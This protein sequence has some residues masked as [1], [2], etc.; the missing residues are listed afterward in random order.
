MRVS[1]CSTTFVHANQCMSPW[2]YTDSCRFSMSVHVH[3]CS[4][5]GYSAVPIRA[6]ALRPH[7]HDLKTYHKYSIDIYW[8]RTV[9]V[10]SLVPQSV[11]NGFYSS[12]DYRTDWLAVSHTLGLWYPFVLTRYPSK[13]NFIYHVGMFRI[14]CWNTSTICTLINAWK[15]I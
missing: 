7:L 6:T 15:N 1:R 11:L 12:C 13:S 10:P 2:S 14:S 3:F 4:A 9:E 8:L 5:A